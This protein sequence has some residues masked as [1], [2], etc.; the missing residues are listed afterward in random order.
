[1][2]EIRKRKK[3]NIVQ[4]MFIIAGLAWFIS[5]DENPVVRLEAILGLS[6]SP[7]E[8]LFGVK[9]VFSGMTEACHKITNFEFKK[10]LE[11]NFLVPIF[12]ILGIYFVLIG[13]LPK[14]D[15]KRKE[16][17]FFAITL[18]LSILINIIN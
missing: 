9:S 3:C 7:I 4:R 18:I 15:S 6:P 11:V 13:K 10:A 12:V 14:I 8:K 1:M 2:I 17:S 5:L 16:L